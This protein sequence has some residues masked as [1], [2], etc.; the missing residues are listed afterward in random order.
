MIVLVMIDLAI[1]L[2]Y[3]LITNMLF[4]ICVAILST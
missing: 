2:S 3:M 1:A 4:F